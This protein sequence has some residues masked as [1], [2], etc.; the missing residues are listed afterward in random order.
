MI[1]EVAGLEPATVNEARDILMEL[2]GS[3]H[4]SV[5][6]FGTEAG[7]FSEIGMNVAVCGPGSI[8]QAHKPDE[9][10]AIDQL[11]KCLAMLDGLEANLT[12]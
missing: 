2:T 3:N 6:P 7:I 9:Y 10:L 11:Q 4:S 1:G 5:V 12:A 8:E